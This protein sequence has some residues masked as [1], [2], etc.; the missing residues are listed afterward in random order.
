MDASWVS[1][2]P[3]PR[4]ILTADEISDTTFLAYVFLEKRI[5]GGCMIRISRVVLIFLI[6]FSMAA[7]AAALDPKGAIPLS[8]TDLARVKVGVKAPGF[9]LEDID[10]RQVSLS[11]FRGKQHVILVF[12]RGHW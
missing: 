10:G 12:Y 7:T 2:Q 5:I 11:D 1:S 6:S 4:R 3:R 9:M 8:P